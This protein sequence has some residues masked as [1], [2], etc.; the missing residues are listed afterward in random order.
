MSDI[1]PDKLETIETTV[2]GN[3][4]PKKDESEVENIGTDIQWS[5]E[6]DTLLSIWCDYSK[7]Y[8][9]MHQEAY[10]YNYSRARI[11]T[12]YLIISTAITGAANISVGGASING[13][14]VSWIFGSLSVLT[15][16]V[17]VIQDKL[18]L[19]QNAEGH[20]RFCNSWEKI[21]R[22]IESE[23]IIPYKTRKD[24]SSFLNM[25]KSDI[26]SLVS[27]GN[28]KIP[29]H[30]R[31]QCCQKFSEIPD[32]YVPDICGNITHTKIHLFE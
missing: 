30:I 22:R 6:I 1:L 28:L 17:N 5:V 13:F 14:Q 27:D 7:C 4:E 20:K 24:C 16:I 31:E 26:S 8:Q 19:S 29:K 23:L 15:S 11:L 21:R 12:L 2:D 9:Y 18:G 25:V 10:D 3:S 32:L